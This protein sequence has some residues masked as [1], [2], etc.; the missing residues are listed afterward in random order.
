MDLLDVPL[1]ELALT[2]NVDPATFFDRCEAIAKV[3]N[4]GIDRRRAYAGPGFDHLNLYI[5][6]GQTRD[7][8]LRMVATP[9]D[10]RR[11]SLDVVDAWKTWPVSYDEYLNIAKRGYRVLLD[12]YSK[13]HAKRFRLGIPRRPDRVDLAAM[14]CGKIGYAAEKFGGL[15]RYLA[16]GP[17]DARERLISAFWSFHVIRPKDLPPPLRG[18][19]EW[20][21]KQI[22][23]RPARHR[24]EGSVEASV[25]TMKNATAAK[26]LERLVD[27][28]DAIDVLEEHC[29]RRQGFT[30]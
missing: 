25:R 16:V 10:G 1:P 26:I 14:N 4:W 18:H 20:V 28:A 21:Y 23:R 27:L 30:R 7:P 13:A 17:G 11:L 19:L 8:M 24:M 15:S 6:G 22:T 12:A 5:G 29:N 2:L 9:R 3:K